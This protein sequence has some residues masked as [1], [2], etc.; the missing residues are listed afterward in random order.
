VPLVD[1]LVSAQS[2]EWRSCDGHGD[3]LVHSSNVTRLGWQLDHVDL[4]RTCQAVRCLV[5]A[6]TSGE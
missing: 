6:A 5:T 3:E 4:G 1:S 2:R